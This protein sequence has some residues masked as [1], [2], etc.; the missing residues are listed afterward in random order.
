MAGCAEIHTGLGDPPGGFYRVP[1]LAPT[2]LTFSADEGALGY[3]VVPMAGVEVE[4]QAAVMN[5]EVRLVTAVLNR[6]RAP[7]RYDLRRAVVTAGAM[8]LDL[9]G[10]ADAPSRRPTREDRSKDEYRTGI[11]EIRKGE[12]SV[13]TRRYRL[14][15]GD[16]QDAGSSLEQLQLVDELTTD[17]GA[18]RIELRFERSR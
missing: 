7:V 1:G 15:E 4:V 3:R 17:D 9:A 5:G 6:G 2:P 13:I 11:R 14:G 16:A 8:P 10:F 12:R 18:G